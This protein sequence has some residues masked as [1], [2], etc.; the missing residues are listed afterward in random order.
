MTQVT[1]ASSLVLIVLNILSYSHAASRNSPQ[2][3]APVLLNSYL[4]AAMQ[5][6]AHLT[7]LMKYDVKPASYFTTTPKPTSPHWPSIF[8]P[9]RPPKV[10]ALKNIYYE[11]SAP[12]G[13]IPKESPLEPRG[14]E[15][16]NEYV[17]GP[18]PDDLYLFGIGPS[19]LL[20]I[21]N[22]IDENNFENEERQVLKFLETYDD[23]NVKQYVIGNK[24][25]PP[26]RAY[27]TLLS[28]YDQLNAEAKKLKLSKYGG[29]TPIVLKFLEENCTGTSTHQL[30]SVLH[31]TIEN[32]D[33]D[34]AKVIERI[35]N[36]IKDLETAN[37][38]V[39]QA[40]L[41]VPPLHFDFF[42]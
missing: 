22:K 40:L 42:A 16:N 35:N 19:Q 4:P 26:T 39:N 36:M 20:N 6:I 32:R 41:Y 38:Y 9:T 5:I 37:S 30:L 18:L 29:Y 25:T 11:R 24:K 3:E 14:N 15:N 13:E 23:Y 12:N 8:A 1:V 34:N 7:D 10:P 2:V 17:N 27:V 33:T 28:L 31:K 21:I